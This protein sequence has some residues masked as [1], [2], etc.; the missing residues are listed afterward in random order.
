MARNRQSPELTDRIYTYPRCGE[1]IDQVSRMA[2]R[3]FRLKNFKAVKDSGT[4]V[5]TPLTVF[6]G[7]NGSCK[8]SIIEGL[9]TY[10]TMVES[11]LDAAMNRWRGWG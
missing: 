9:I 10:Q 4:I 8:S 5:F 2:I 11:G 6:A 1:G 7:N 3:T